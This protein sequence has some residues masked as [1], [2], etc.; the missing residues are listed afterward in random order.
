MLAMLV[1]A[2]GRCLETEDFREHLAEEAM[3]LFQQWYE[4]E[5]SG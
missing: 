4:K 3:S 1:P 5:E 2:Q